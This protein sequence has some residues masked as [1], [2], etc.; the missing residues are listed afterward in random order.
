[1]SGVESPGTIDHDIIQ[2]GPDVAKQV[3]LGSQSRYPRSEP[4]RAPNR[5]GA[6]SSDDCGDR[7]R[8]AVRARCPEGVVLRI[9]RVACVV[10]RHGAHGQRADALPER[11]KR[12][13]SS[14]RSGDPCSARQ[15]R[16]RCWAH[17][18]SSRCRG[19]LATSRAEGQSSFGSS[20]R[21]SVAARL[22][23][24]GR[25]C[26]LPHGSPGSALAATRE[27]PRR[28]VTKGFT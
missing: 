4:G 21:R 3:A 9:G 23:A 8:V 5:S 28:L 10:C 17:P 16:R 14:R 26:A 7:L 2:R 15:N 6:D 27:A 11:S 24:E 19:R 12:G 25:E 1:L 13:T 20:S 18:N 22:H